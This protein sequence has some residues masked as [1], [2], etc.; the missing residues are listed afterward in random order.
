M[1]FFVAGALMLGSACNTYTATTDVD[2]KGTGYGLTDNQAGTGHTSSP[3]VAEANDNATLDN[4][5]TQSPKDTTAVAKDTA[6]TTTA[7]KKDTT[8]K[9]Q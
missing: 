4:P 3:A 7:A 5:E 8:A 9:K 2:D 6:A 1:P